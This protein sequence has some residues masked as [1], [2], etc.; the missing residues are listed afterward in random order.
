MSSQCHA[1]T[2]SLLQ[3]PTD[4]VRVLNRSCKVLSSFAQ[5]TRPQGCFAALGGAAS[6]K[7]LC[8]QKLVRKG[9]FG[10]AV[11]HEWLDGL[12]AAGQHMQDHTIH[13]PSGTRSWVMQM[14]TE[15]VSAVEQ[16]N[17][18]QLGNLCVLLMKRYKMPINIMRV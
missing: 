5:H 2:S 17:P 8:M 4:P 13:L 15:L 12:E 3:G 10:S 16:E 9:V 11:Y 1:V 6:G 7:W 14:A 18:D